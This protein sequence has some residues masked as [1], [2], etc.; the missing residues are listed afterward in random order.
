MLAVLDWELSTV[1]HPL[2]DLAFLCVFSLGQP[3]SL[4]L[5]EIPPSLTPSP[6]H[7]HT[8]MLAHPHTLTDDGMVP[9]DEVPGSLSEL[10]VTRTYTGLTRWPHPLPS[11][12]FFKALTCFRMA[13]IVQVAFPPCCVV[14]I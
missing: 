2:A 6:P 12:N 10:D 5:R 1:G 14:G 8:L 9:D 13:A 3:G 11:W 7:P 4:S